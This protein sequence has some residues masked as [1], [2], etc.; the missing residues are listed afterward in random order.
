MRDLSGLD[1]IVGRSEFLHLDVPAEIRMRLTDPTRRQWPSIRNGELTW[2]TEAEF[3]DKLDR[4]IYQ[5][6]RETHN[7]TVGHPTYLT[8]SDW[9]SKRMGWAASGGA[10]GAHI[11]WHGDGKRERMNKRG[12]VLIIPEEHIRS[13]LEAACPPVLWSKCAPKYENGKMRAIWNTAVEY[14]VIQAYLADLF[15]HSQD[16]ATWDSA[17]HN[18]QQKVAADIARLESLPLVLGSCG[19]IAILI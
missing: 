19:I 16:N 8:F 13:I 5:A 9:Y 4:A 7:P 11:S 18:I 3:T 14:Y 12:A 2:S 6:V 1:T 10:P 17:H 15:E